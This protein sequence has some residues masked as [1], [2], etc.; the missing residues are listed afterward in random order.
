M[1]CEEFEAIG[2]ERPRGVPETTGRRKN[3]HEFRVVESLT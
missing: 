3:A 2:L 1:T